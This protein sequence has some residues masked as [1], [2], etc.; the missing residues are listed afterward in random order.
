[1]G[2]PRVQAGRDA[3]GDPVLP[4]MRHDDRDSLDLFVV[5]FD[6]TDVPFESDDILPASK[7][8][9][10]D[11]QPDPAVLFYEGFDLRRNLSKVV[12]F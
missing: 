9:S 11:Q 6:E 8:S 2:L 3:G 12:S 7:S 5:R 10:V 1:L 4:V